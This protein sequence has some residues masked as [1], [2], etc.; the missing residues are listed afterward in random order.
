MAKIMSSSEFQKEVLAEGAGKYLVDFFAIWCGPCRMV[1]PILDEI[2][3]EYAQNI[4]VVKIDTDKSPD[5]AASYRISAVPTLML[6][7]GGKPIKTM[8][9]ANSKDAIL[10]F[11]GLK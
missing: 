9:G 3:Q 7:D 4:Q 11:A 8:V 5:I 1:A 6:F 2:S 10:S